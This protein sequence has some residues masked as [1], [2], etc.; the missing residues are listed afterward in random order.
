MES[1]E[2]NQINKDIRDRIIDLLQQEISQL[3]H[4]RDIL[5]AERRVLGSHDISQIDDSSGQKRTAVSA[6]ENVSRQR[7]EY[8]TSLGINPQ[9]ENW[10]TNVLQKTGDHQE[11]TKIY[12][13]LIAATN[14]CR[15]M[16]QINGLLINR[17]ERMTSEVINLLRANDLPPIY[18]E[19]GQ[20]VTASSARTIGKA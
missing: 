2:A 7:F 17:R 11:L 6:L 19:Q 5:E 15:S 20:S 16:N 14:Q 3:E 13:H 9:E 1:Q 8:L 4:L 10:F 12:E 18:S